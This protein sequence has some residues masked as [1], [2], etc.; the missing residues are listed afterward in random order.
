MAN[1]K[2]TNLKQRIAKFVKNYPFVLFKP[3][4]S[5]LGRLIYEKTINSSNDF[6]TQAPY[7]VKTKRASN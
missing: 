2:E 4:D 6:A 3:M 7:I 5:D 1:L